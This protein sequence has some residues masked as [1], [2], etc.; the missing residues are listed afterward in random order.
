M[1][2]KCNVFIEMPTFLS[3]SKNY[4]YFLVHRKK[5]IT[6]VLINKKIWEIQNLGKN[7]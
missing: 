1:Q 5:I 7:P 6:I 4:Y 2:K 3:L